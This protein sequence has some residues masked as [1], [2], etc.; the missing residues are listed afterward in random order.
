MYKKITFLFLACIS[1]LSVSAQNTRAV[2]APVAKPVYNFITINPKLKYVFVEDKPTKGHP[3]EGDDV[4]M[5]MIAICNNRFLYHS[6]QLYKGKPGAFS[7]S[8]AAFQGDIADALM[9]MTPGDSLICLV[10]AKSVFDY[11][12]KKLPDYIKPGDL[13]QYNIRLVSIKPKAEIQKEREAAFAKQMNDQQV[14]INSDAA[15][16]MAEDDK[17]LNNYFNNKHLTPIKSNSGMYYSIQKEGNGKQAMPGDTVVMNYRGNLLDGTIFDS[18]IDSAFQHVQPLTFVLGTGRVIKGWDEGIS[19]LKAGSKASFYIPA[20][21]GYGSQSRPGS[22][23][24]P[25]G[26]PSNSVLIFDVELVA[27]KGK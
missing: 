8:K 10:D 22:A 15:K 14:Q 21:L 12:K 13:V 19:Y 27:V 23:A 26:I 24:N 4:M 1:A 3:Q 20:S 6:G 25:K 5:H 11:S 7:I 9:L 18:N 16:L 17:A 2:A